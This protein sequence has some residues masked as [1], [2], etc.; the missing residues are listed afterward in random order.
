MK[1]CL[2][3]KL[4]NGENCCPTLV[5]VTPGVYEWTGGDNSKI[6]INTTGAVG[7]FVTY[8]TKP[9]VGSTVV[10]LPMLP[11]VGQLMLV[12]RNGHD[13]QED[14]YSILGANVTF[15]ESFGPSAGGA[16]EEEVLFQYY[17]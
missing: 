17:T 1:K 6:T 8:G 15:V 5:E 7:T 10:S 4:N 2:F 13:L 12:T 14:E 3:V 11:I 9:P 16:G